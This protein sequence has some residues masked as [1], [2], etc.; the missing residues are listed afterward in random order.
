MGSD[1]GNVVLRAGDAGRPPNRL[2]GAGGSVTIQAGSAGTGT[3]LGGDIFL[4]SGVGGSGDLTRHGR[5]IA[6]GRAFE[7]RPPPATAGGSSWSQINLA[8]DSTGQQMFSIRVGLRSSQPLI[9]KCGN[10]LLL[11]AVLCRC[12]GCGDTG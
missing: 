5:V 8:L 9:T 2:S 6:R 4:E 1:G 3:R 7:I 10:L 11:K 12:M